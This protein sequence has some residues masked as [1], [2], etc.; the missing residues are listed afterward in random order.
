MSILN[1]NTY[2]ILPPVGKE[3][4]SFM[5]EGKTDQTARSI[6]SKILIKVIDYVLSIDTFGQNVLC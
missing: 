1:L 2:T 3:Y 5:K 6:K 4:M